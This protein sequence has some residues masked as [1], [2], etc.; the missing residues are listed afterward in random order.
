[1][2]TNGIILTN[3]VRDTLRPLGGLWA[4]NL[5]LLQIVHVTLKYHKSVI[6]Y[7]VW[8]MYQWIEVWE[9]G[10]CYGS[11]GRLQHFSRPVS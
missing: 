4:S 2:L 9:N 5:S 8:K 11:Y 10:R 3:N 6:I 7:C 1:M